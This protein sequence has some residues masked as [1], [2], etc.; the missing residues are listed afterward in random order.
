M[1]KNTPYTVRLDSE[2]LENV[3][4]RADKEGQ[5]VTAIFEQALNSF[6]SS[7]NDKPDISDLVKRIEALEAR[8]TRTT[9][10]PEEITRELITLEE[11]AKL[12]GYAKS[13][14]ERKKSLAGIKRR[15][16]RKKKALYDKAEIMDKIGMID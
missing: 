14:F 8:T 4:S 9:Q 12:T 10:P 5:T 16:T 15:D 3:K 13:T 1:A 6:L 7:S 11:G 2:L